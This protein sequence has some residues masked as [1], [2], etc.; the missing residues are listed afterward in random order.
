M[1]PVRPV[2]EG[3]CARNPGL[4]SGCGM[5]AAE[6]LR[7]N[8]SALQR[9]QLE[10][11]YLLVVL[12]ANPIYNLMPACIAHVDL[13]RRLTHVLPAIPSCTYHTLSASQSAVWSFPSRQSRHHTIIADTFLH[14]PL[15][16]VSL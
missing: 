8:P 9:L 1:S 2:S 14:L 5:Q 6:L 7:T 11:Q 12:T 10:H 4:L 13:M 15:P 3:S 16:T